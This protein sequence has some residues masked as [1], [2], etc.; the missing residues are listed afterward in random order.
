MN[1]S[2]VLVNLHHDLGEEIGKTW[3]LSVKSVAEAV[4]AIESI[5]HKFYKYLL[6]KDKENIGYQ[7]IVNGIPLN[8]E[9]IDKNNL[10]SIKN[11]ELCLRYEKLQSIDI[12]PIMEGAN[13]KT[14][15]YVLSA[16][17]I[18]VGIVLS[19][20][21]AA[22]IGVPLIIAGLGLLITT[23]L[24]KPPKFEDFRE[25]SQGGKT[26]YLY[27][28]PANI[29]GEGGPVPVGYGRLIVGSQ[30]VTASYVIREFDAG[31]TSSYYNSV[32]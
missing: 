31:N 9:G 20:V 6:L 17:L 22:A 18:V 12:I 5:T 32:Y 2:L 7:I 25:I 23:L 4:R 24:S 1:D 30:T 27:G 13:S 29:I 28:G 16:I 3:E 10:E 26:S 19:I 21:T 8:T 15:G 11:S 14:L